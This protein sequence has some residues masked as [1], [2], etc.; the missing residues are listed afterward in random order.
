MKKTSD[1]ITSIII[2]YNDIIQSF[3]GNIRWPHLV[4]TSHSEC[5]GAS[6]TTN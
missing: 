5:E 4:T 1:K 3:I 2:M 6:A